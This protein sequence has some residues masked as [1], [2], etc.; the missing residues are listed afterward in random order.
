MGIADDDL[1][2]TSRR[3]LDEVDEVKRLELDKRYEP[4]GTDEF[5]E[6]AG[7]VEQRARH[8]LELAQDETVGGEEDSPIPAERQERHA[9]DWADS[10]QR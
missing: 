9:G 2:A 4:R 5:H 1:D 6:L 7:Q 8:V 3:L 10:A